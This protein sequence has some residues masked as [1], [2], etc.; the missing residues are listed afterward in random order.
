MLLSAM[1]LFHS[2][3]SLEEE[4]DY[5]EFTYKQLPPFPTSQHVERQDTS[6]PDTDSRTTTLMTIGAA[7][8]AANL[9]L[10][11]ALK[12]ERPKLEN[13]HMCGIPTDGKA[14]CYFDCESN[15]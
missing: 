11:I 2:K 4:G 13:D 14:E 12:P 6:P 9:L 7:F 1:G 3:A 15:N 10:A 5:E 8:V